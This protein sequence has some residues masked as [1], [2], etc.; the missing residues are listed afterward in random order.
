MSTA[1]KH[2]VTTAAPWG[3]LGRTPA[4]LRAGEAVAFAALT[5]ATI[6]MAVG[7]FVWL[8]RAA[9]NFAG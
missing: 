5:A 2:L 4:R 6:A 9:A 8:D 3:R 1:A 7:L